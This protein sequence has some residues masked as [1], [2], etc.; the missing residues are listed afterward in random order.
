MSE[1]VTLLQVLKFDGVKKHFSNPQL[2]YSGLGEKPTWPSAH[3]GVFHCRESDGARQNVAIKKYIE[4][5]KDKQLIESEIITMT[6]HRHP[7]ILRLQSIYS[8]DSCVFLVTPYYNGGT[9]QKYCLDNDVALLQMVFILKRLVA[10]L[11]EIHKRGSIHRNI[12]CENVFLGEDNSIVIGGFGFS[13]LKPM[14][15]GESAE[16]AGD[17]LFWAPEICKGKSINQMVDIWALGIVVLEILSIGKAPY[18]D[19]HLGK[20]EV[21]L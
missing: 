3:G 10:G 11:A 4:G 8:Y 19:D 16:E 9:L 2:I 15:I 6:K 14:I 20:E 7:N 21:R 12:K 5:N 18:Q 13:S 17:I 1:L